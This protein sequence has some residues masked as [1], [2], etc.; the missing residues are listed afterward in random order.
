MNR[1][2]IWV[3]PVPAA[4]RIKIYALNS[5]L[6]LQPTTELPYSFLRKRKLS[7]TTPKCSCPSARLIFGHEEENSPCSIGETAPKF[8]VPFHHLR[9]FLDAYTVKT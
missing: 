4:G 7:C 3:Y 8:H 9:R 5:Y 2:S 6:A 1:L